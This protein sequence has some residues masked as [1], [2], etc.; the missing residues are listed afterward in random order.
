[1]APDV[2]ALAAF[3]SLLALLP[4][5]DAVAPGDVFDVNPWRVG[6]EGSTEV[7]VIGR[8]FVVGANAQCRL[9]ISPLSGCDF[10]IQSDGREDRKVWGNW[11]HF[12]AYFIIQT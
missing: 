1:M 4:V 6:I 12:A 10:P 3:C 2:L 8:N 5:G 9:E 7:T 11:A